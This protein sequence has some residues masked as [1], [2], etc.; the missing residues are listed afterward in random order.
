MDASK[1]DLSKIDRSKLNVDRTKINRDQIQANL[2]SRDQNRLDNKV[3]NLQRPT[4][5]P[6][7][8][9][10]R[11]QTK[12]IRKNIEQGL[13]R[14]AGEGRPGV[15]NKLPGQA[16]GGNMANKLPA[17]SISATRPTSCRGMRPTSCREMR[18]TSCRATSS[19]QAA[20]TA[21][22]RGR[23]SCR[24]VAR[25]CNG[26]TSSVPRRAAS[27]GE[28]GHPTGQAGGDRDYDRGTKVREASNRAKVSREA[29]QF[30][31]PSGG[32]GRD[33]NRGG[34]GGGQKMNR[35]G[36]GGR[37]VQAGGGRGRRG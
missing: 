1:L 13:K 5:L 21:S 16:G 19:A 28:A 4:T 24:R 23:P 22:R 9:N 34:G 15:S 20:A 7:A 14:P 3:G 10:D 37:K 8:V 32:G 27:S 30:N 33:F 31:R 29:P 2:K 6:G 11:P 26:P 36:G 18:P 17:T 12:D 25:V 35:G